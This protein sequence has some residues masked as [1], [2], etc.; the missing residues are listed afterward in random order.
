MAAA[1][2]PLLGAEAGSLFGG[3]FG[4]GPS[5][6]QKALAGLTANIGRFGTSAGEADIS[7]SQNFWSAIL[8]GDP[9]KIA[10]V[11][12]PEMST[13]N[14]QGQ[15]RKQ[16]TAQ[17]GTRSGGTTG[18]MQTIDDSTL[19]SIRGMISQL[20]GGA[21]TSLGS[22]GTSLLNTG[23]QGTTSAMG[24]A[25][26]MQQANAAKWADIFGSAGLL[27]G[28]LGKWALTPRPGGGGGPTD[29]PLYGS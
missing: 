13:F 11:L 21:A 9:T 16:T 26:V 23:L 14:R 29:V 5:P 17:F 15:Q 24:E 8:S 12:G 28:S 22:L 27:G 1:A 2:L 19:A 25:N 6:E 3:I 4:G 7:K 20:T 18:E 10:T